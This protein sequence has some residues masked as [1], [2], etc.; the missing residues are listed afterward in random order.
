LLPP[1]ANGFLSFQLQHFRTNQAPVLAPIPDQTIHAGVTLTI[2]N[3]ATDADL[4]PDVLTF[5]LT[6]APWSA[7]IDPSGVFTW[8][9]SE[10][11]EFTTNRVT[12]R[13]TD[14]GAPALSDSKSFQVAVKSRLRVGEVTIT[15]TNVMLS[16]FSIPGTAYRVQFKD[17]FNHPTWHDLLPDVA[18]SGP[19]ATITD[20]SPLVAQRFY[21]VI[22]RP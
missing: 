15:E 18:A 5:S 7:F 8:T 12:V 10:V 17:D 9:P 2:T 3:V 6:T 4:P 14:N 22:L 20:H 19:T 11:L 1:D 16:W 13:V 21:R